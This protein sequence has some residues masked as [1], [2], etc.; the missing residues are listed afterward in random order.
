MIQLK[1]GNPLIFSPILYDNSSL[2]HIFHQLQ[3][4]YLLKEY[5]GFP[6]KYATKLIQR[7]PSLIHL[8]LEIYSVD[9]CIPL[10]D[11]LLDGL[12]KLIHLKIH[13]EKNKLLTD[14]TC[15]IDHVIERRH[16]AFPHHVYNR[17][18][19][20]IKIGE[21]IMDIYLTG[22]SICANVKFNV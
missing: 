5:I 20:Y 9:K 13:F 8:E 19:V 7:F 1:I 10:L 22:C 18:E 21:K 16:Q 17:D 14:E 15:L 2:T 12:P 4:L 11:I 6:I 3:S